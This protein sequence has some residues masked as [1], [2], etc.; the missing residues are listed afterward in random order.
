[1]LSPS[2]GGVCI[3]ACLAGPALTIPPP[4]CAKAAALGHTPSVSVV[5]SRSGSSLNKKVARFKCLFALPESSA[6]KASAIFGSARACR[7]WGGGYPCMMAWRRLGRPAVVAFYIKFKRRAAG[8]IFSSRLR[9]RTDAVVM[10]MCQI[11]G[12]KVFIAAPSARN[13]LEA[14]GF[15]L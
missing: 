3:G 15:G 12:L 10:M 7:R 1:M 8:L 11:E 6:Q 9:A 5:P 14:S 13:F 4:P 2:F